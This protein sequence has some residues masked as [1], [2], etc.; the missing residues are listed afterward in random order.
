MPEAVPA[1]ELPVSETSFY[2][3]TENIYTFTQYRPIEMEF[4]YSLLPLVDKA[5]AELY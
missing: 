2:K 4:G 3:N 5:G 1:E